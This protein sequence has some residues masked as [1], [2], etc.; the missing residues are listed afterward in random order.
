MRLVPSGLWSTTPP[1]AMYLVSPCSKHQVQ[2]LA[3]RVRNLN[4]YQVYLVGQVNETDDIFA[5]AVSAA[6][7]KD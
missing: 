4:F 5:T 1:L 6:A 7:V 3:K 2:H